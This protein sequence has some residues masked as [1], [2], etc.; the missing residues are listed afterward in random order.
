LPIYIIF[1]IRLVEDSCSDTA[2]ATAVRLDLGRRDG[3]PR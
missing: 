1:K 2:A 3:R